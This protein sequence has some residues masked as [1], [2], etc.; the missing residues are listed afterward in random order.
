MSEIYILCDN[1]ANYS[2]PKTQERN[3]LSSTFFL[4]QRQIQR[5]KKSILKNLETIFF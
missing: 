5:Q 4:I 3:Y 1:E 2:I